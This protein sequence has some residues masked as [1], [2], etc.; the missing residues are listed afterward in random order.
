MK[1]LTYTYKFSIMLGYLIRFA[2]RVHKR[3]FPFFMPKYYY[4]QKKKKKATEA[5][6]IVAWPRLPAILV[7]EPNIQTL[8]I[9]FFFLK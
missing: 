7:L 3:P 1:Y 6:K 9:T 2:G 8:R 5:Q 4:A